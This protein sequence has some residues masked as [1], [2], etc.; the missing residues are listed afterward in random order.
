MITF[1]VAVGRNGK[2]VIV[3]M[4][5]GVAEGVKGKRCSRCSI[6]DDKL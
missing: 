1:S 5:V 3:A 2:L 6:N 4:N